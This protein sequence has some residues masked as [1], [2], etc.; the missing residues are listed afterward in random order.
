MAQD[1]QFNPAR[2]DRIERRLQALEDA[3]AIRI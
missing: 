2:L 1:D 3:E